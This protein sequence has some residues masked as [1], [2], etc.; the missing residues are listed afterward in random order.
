MAI[1]RNRGEGFPDTSLEGEP[2]VAKRDVRRWFNL[3]CLSASFDNRTSSCWK[4]NDDGRSR[5]EGLV[6]IDGCK[7]R[8]DGW[9]IR[10]VAKQ[11]SS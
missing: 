3:N 4:S 5:E 6:V 9:E 10:W 1:R 11:E 7:E 8:K 2:D